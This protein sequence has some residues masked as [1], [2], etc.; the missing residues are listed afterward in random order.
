MLCCR[1]LWKIC[2]AIVDLLTL[3]ATAYASILVL[4]GSLLT[5]RLAPKYLEIA[6]IG[7]W[8]FSGD[9]SDPH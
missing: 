7:S 3:T 6:A 9:D 5:F 1:F 2:A 8:E 4:L